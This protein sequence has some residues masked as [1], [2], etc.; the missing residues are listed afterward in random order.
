VRGGV[1]RRRE[2]GCRGVA[3]KRRRVIEGQESGKS[4]VAQGR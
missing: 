2:G 4:I 3:R 1:Y